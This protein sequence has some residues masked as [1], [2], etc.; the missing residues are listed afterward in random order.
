MSMSRA[1]GFLEQERLTNNRS[2]RGSAHDSR[3]LS[4]NHP[5]ERSTRSHQQR[6]P[7][8]SLSVRQ[9]EVIANPE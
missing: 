3:R 9:V 4:G 5:G 7:S 6:G 8:F 2:G 1:G